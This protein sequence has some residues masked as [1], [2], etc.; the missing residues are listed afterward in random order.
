MKRLRLLR[1]QN[2]LYQSHLAQLYQVESGL[3][4]ILGSSPVIQKLKGLIGRVANSTITVCISGE[5][6]TGKELVANAIH[7]LSKRPEK[8]FVKI[9]CAAI[10][11]DLLEFGALRL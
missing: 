7:K 9:N 1:H 8:P 3:D 6:G 10:P 4:H 5:T 11:E 2:E